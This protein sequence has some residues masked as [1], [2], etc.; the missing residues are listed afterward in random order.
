MPIFGAANQ[1]LA[2]VALL[3]VA[4]WLANAGRNNKMLI[5]PMIFMFIV[6]LTALVFLV[7]SNIASGNYILV[8]FAVLLFVLAILLILQTYGV[9]TG[10][11]R[12]EGVAR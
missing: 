4:A 8:L 2:A 7:R 12:K 3:A 5:I 9:L 11:N 6:T 1:L 10:K